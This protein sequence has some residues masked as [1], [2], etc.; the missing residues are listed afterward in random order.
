M[1]GLDVRQDRHRR[2]VIT[3]GGKRRVTRR[4]RSMRRLV[5]AINAKRRWPR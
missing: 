5:L 4:K 3:L 2:W 1:A